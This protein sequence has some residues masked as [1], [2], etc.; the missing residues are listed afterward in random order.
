MKKY[1]L[2]NRIRGKIGKAIFDY[3]M[4]SE[5]DHVVV[6]LS[7]GKDSVFLLVALSQIRRW[8]PV[9]FDLSACSVD[10]SG[11]NWD[12]SPMERLCDEL[13]ILY[14]VVPHPIEE[15]IR[16]REERSPCSF[17]ANMRRGILNSYAKEM[18]GNTVALGHNLDDA[19][20][21]ALMNLFRTGR[22]RSFQP[23]IWQSNSDM[24]LIRPLLY[25][26]EK[27]ILQEISRMGLPLVRYTCPFSLE[28]ER[29]RA[30]EL[31]S[32]LAARFPDVKQNIL[33][34][35]RSIDGKD[36]WQAED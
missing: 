15:I 24:N 17:C 12:V 31:V 2:G 22:F 10:I 6:G 21:T 13:K 14:K 9:K 25:L 18:G 20:E 36:R 28:T 8:S 26:T 3:D 7:G 16:I 19:V 33:H 11:G 35:L 5:G 1:S 4:V 29:T 30:K 23:R 32:D 27:A 34:A